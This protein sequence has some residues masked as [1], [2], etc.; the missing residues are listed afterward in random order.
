MCNAHRKARRK[1]HF[2]FCER[3]EQLQ[4]TQIC[5]LHFG[6]GLWS[7]PY[8]AFNERHFWCYGERN[9]GEFQQGCW[10]NRPSDTTKPSLP[11]R[12]EGTKESNS[13]VQSLWDKEMYACE[14]GMSNTHWFGF[15]ISKDLP[16]RLLSS[17]RSSRPRN[18]SLKL[19]TISG[20]TKVENINSLARH[21]NSTLPQ[22]QLIEQSDLWPQN[23]NYH[24]TLPLR[25]TY[26]LLFKT[27]K[28]M[29]K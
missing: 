27:F 26:V 11:V 16:T 24:V 3:S 18:P 6:P 21:E 10:R 1:K 15:Q 8:R 4:L 9:T 12:K 2:A 23:M 14:N 29:L 20:S 22:Q 19:W 25:Q 17:P 13:K 5:S 28:C 7:G